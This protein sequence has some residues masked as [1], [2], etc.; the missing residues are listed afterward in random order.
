[1]RLGKA[2]ELLRPEVFQV[3]QLADLPAGRFGDHQRVR[4]GQGLQ[5]SGKVRRLADDPALLRCA[6][7]DQIADHGEPGGD[8]KPHAQI[9]ALRQPAD[10]SDHREGRAHRPLGIVLM[11]PRISKIN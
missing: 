1:L 3:K 10:R 9:F 6:F 4:R 11:G 7:A 5:P 8:A 2:G